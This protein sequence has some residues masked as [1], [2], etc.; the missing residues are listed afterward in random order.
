MCEILKSVGAHNVASMDGGGSAQMMLQGSIVNKPADGKER[1]VA[2]GWMLFSTAPL[3]ESISTI[4]FSDYT[5]VIPA[6]AS[7]KPEFFGMIIN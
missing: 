5:V 7:Y 6:N 3:D 4:D 2:N 1:P